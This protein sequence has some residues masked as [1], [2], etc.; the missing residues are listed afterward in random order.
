MTLR[1][2]RSARLA[3]VLLAVGVLLAACSSESESTGGASLAGAADGA[4]GPGADGA[5]ASDGSGATLTDGAVVPASDASVT[6]PFD[7]GTVVACTGVPDSGG[8]TFTT[9]CTLNMPLS[10]A[11]TTTLDTTGCARPAPDTFTWDATSSAGK[12]AVK[13]QLMAPLAVDTVGVFPLKAFELSTT[14]SGGNKWTAP[15]GACSIAIT[16]SECKPSKQHPTQRIVSGNGACA[17][18]LTGASG[19]PMNVAPFT[20]LV[21]FDP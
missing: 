14:A 7:G 10:G 1:T 18:P 6:L 19:G 13:M 3:L 20:F 17:Q 4:A 9:V 8:L 21:A 12:F 11:A 2:R 5:S 16:K 15:S